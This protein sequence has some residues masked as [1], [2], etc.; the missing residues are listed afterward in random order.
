MSPKTAPIY[1]FKVT[2]DKTQ[3]PIWRR[4]LVSSND[5]LGKLHDILQIVM[6][7]QD[8]H[9]H[10]FAIGGQHYGKPQND[11]FGE[12][13][14]LDERDYRL[15]KL[16]TWEGA[17]F[18]Y[19]YDFGDSWWHTLKL[20]KILPPHPKQL[21][22]E[23]LAGRRACP[24]EDVG[25]VW[26]YANFL[27]ALRDSSHEEHEASLVWV[28]GEFNPA[29]FDLAGVNRALRQ[30]NRRTDKVWESYESLT[31]RVGMFEEA[32][33]LEALS[34]EAHQQMDA[35]PLRRDAYALLTYLQANKVTG[36]Q[37]G[38]LPLKAVRALSSQFVVPFPLEETMGSHVFRVRSEEEVWP[39]YFVRGL[40]AV[41]GL[42][43]G[44]PSRR[45]K[46][47]P[48]GETFLMTSAA[49]QV[50]RLF[51][52]WWRRVNWGMASS[53]APDD[54]PPP[55]V[56]QL[57]LDHLL[58]LPVAR[59]QPFPAF[60]DPFIAEAGLIWPGEDRQRGADIL[61][62]VVELTIL[63]PLT[64]FGVLTLAYG[65]HPILGAPYRKLETLILTTLGRELLA[66]VKA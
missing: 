25:G 8:Y 49:G 29:A 24:P 6:G 38:N 37:A 30:M 13:G 2:L 4:F 65:T 56:R 20:E 51:H 52:T 18:Q 1:Q 12:L 17:R 35:L 22:P 57:A 60:A 40:A 48:E 5:T 64:S 27:E 53:Y 61:R 41:G 14:C 46:L 55:F 19:E 62:S 28:G 3:P 39:L 21:L 43:A 59:P 33:W 45:W 54:F 66:R 11:E 58:H 26:G 10:M 47:T 31:G 16:V 34:D 42:I 7:W 44:G 63:Q 9:L 50:G 32:A 36:T 23:C 15:R